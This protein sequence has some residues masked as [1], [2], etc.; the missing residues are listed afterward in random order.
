MRLNNSSS[1]TCPVLTWGNSLR[2]GVTIDFTKMK[3]VEKYNWGLILV[4][5]G[6]I[7]FWIAMVT[8]LFLGI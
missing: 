4:L 1:S 6:A 2:Y 5:G 7:L 3:K 8:L